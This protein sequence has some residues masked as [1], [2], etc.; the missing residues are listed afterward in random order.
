M[1]ILPFL[2]PFLTHTTFYPL[3]LLLSSSSSPSLSSV[4]HP[5]LS[6]SFLS[7]LTLHFSS[8]PSLLTLSSSPS[9]SPTRA[10]FSTPLRVTSA[11]LTQYCLRTCRTVASMAAKHLT[12]A[13][14]RYVHSVSSYSA[15]L[16][17]LEL[18]SIY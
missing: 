18:Y 7:S 11:D 5:F 13:L 4:T 8:H 3:P 2:S 15:N 14:K 17:D 16:F 6:C 12:V 9:P 1:P 10:L